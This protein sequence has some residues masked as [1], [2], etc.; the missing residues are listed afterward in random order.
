MIKKSFFFFSMLIAITILLSNCSKGPIVSD[1]VKGIYDTNKKFLTNKS[2]K[3]KILTGD[4][5][6]SLSKKYSLTKKELINFNKLKYPYILKP[7]QYIKIPSPKRYKIKRGD[8]LYKIA[9]CNS[10]NIS[11]IRTKNII[12]NEKKLL[13]GKI[14]YLPYYAKNSCNTN[15]KN[16]SKNLKYV[17]KKMVRMV[18][19]EPTR[20]TGNRF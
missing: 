19:I 20:P 10:L 11:E 7:G 1:I 13:V 4:T 12:V 17:N 5:I 9:K 18:G 3:V 16:Y 6:I 2:K 8:T 15:I 14:I